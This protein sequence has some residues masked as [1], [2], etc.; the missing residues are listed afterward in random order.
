MDHKSLLLFGSDRQAKDQRIF[1][2][3]NR[4]LTSP[5]AHSFDFDIFYASKLDLDSFQQ[6]LVALPVSAEKRVVIL[7]DC[8]KLVAR[9]QDFLKSYISK[10]SSSVILVLDTDASDLKLVFFKSILPHVELLKFGFSS[11]K[12][13]FDVTKAMSQNQPSEALKLLRD[14]MDDGQHPL[15]L[16]GGILWFWKNQPLKLAAGRKEKGLRLIQEADLN[17]KR[18]RMMPEQSVEVLVVKLCSLITC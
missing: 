10:V 6:S 11:P 3:K 1:Q 5:E 7:H 12:S 15:Q 16:I 9:A 2:I 4:W 13:I 18:S 8:E 14:V 17:I